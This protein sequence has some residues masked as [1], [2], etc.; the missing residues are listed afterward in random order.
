MSLFVSSLNSGSNGNCYY[1]GSRDEAVFID[2][3]I[4]SRE[5]ERRLK[6]QEL[7]IGRVKAIFITHE[8]ADHV[9]GLRKLAKKYKLPVYMTHETRMETRIDWREIQVRHFV[10]HEEVMVGRLKIIPFPIQHD[11]IDP[12]GFLVSHDATTVG[13]FT[14]L[15]STQPFLQS[16]FGRCHGAFLEANYDEDMLKSGTYPQQ[17]K[18]RISS[19]LGHLSNLQALQFFMSSRPSFMS[20]L[21]LSHLSQHN[22]SPDIAR[23]LFQDVAGTTEIVI[24]SRHSETGVF[25]IDGHQTPRPSVQMKE[26]QLSLF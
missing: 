19:D 14:D 1:I 15:G 5:T 9:G 12:H 26:S 18:D 13:V 25:Y 4:S 22:N 6:R 7:S 20:H 11:A 16:Y 2:A 10:P 23:Q 21:F 17:L 24:A 8:H 3:G